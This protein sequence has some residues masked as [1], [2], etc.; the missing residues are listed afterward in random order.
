MTT[1]SSN[2]AELI[3]L[4]EASR[5]CI[6]LRLLIHHI[7]KKSGIPAC[8]ESPTIIHEDNTACVSH[9]KKGFIKGDRTKHIDPKFFFTHDQTKGRKIK[10]KKIQ[11]C[12]NP[13]D[14][15]T[16]STTNRKILRAYKVNWCTTSSRPTPTLK[17][18]PI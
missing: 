1:T 18:R 2:H 4:Y 12:E 17:G 9:I 11:S 16:K 15:F 7:Q 8:E 3:A 5:E 14:I 10:I 6:W 13:A